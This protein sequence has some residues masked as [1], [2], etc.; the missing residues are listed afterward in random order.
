MILLPPL[1]F[2]P[3]TMLKWLKLKKENIGEEERK[4]KENLAEKKIDYM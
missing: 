1:F 3:P 2:F 4:E